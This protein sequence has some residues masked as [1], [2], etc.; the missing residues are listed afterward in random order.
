MRILMLPLMLLALAG[1][2]TLDPTGKSILQGGTS[3]T[4]AVQN[5][6]TPT[7]TYQVKL[8]FNIAVKGGN[9]WAN[10]CWSKTYAALMADP[11]GSHVCENRRAMRRALSAAADKANA[12]IRTADTFIRNN[13]T[14]S[15]FS[16]IDDAW[17]AVTDYKNL[18]EPITP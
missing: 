13:P 8:A 7:N 5:P 17:R 15:P 11:V 3:I 12:A 10:Y 16:V 18:V 14:I 4:A 1:C 9:R 6:V 2:G